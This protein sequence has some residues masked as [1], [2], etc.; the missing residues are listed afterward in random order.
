ML[1]LSIIKNKLNFIYKLNDLFD[2]REKIQ[3]FGVLAM[4]LAMAIFQAIGVAS[5]FPFINMIMD[6]GV[7]ITNQWLNYSYN[8]LGFNSNNS[9]LI[10]SG[11]IVLGLLII[12]NFIS[13]FAIWFRMRFVWKKSH[14]LSVTLLGK[15]LSMPYTYFLNQN[16]SD[17]GKNVLAEVQQLTANFFL[18]LL[19]IFTNVII[20]A[21]ILML[22]F[23]INFLMTFVA[24][25]ILIFLYFSIFYYYSFRLTKGGI[26]RVEENKERYKAASEALNG[27]KDIK[28]LRVE[29]FF[30]EKFSVSSKKYSQLQSWYQVVGQ[31]PRYFMEIV[32]FGGIV[33]FIIFLVAANKPLTEIIPLVSFFA[34]AGYRLLPSFQD[35]FNSL[36]VLKFNTAVLDKIH[37]DMIDGD[38]GK[39]NIQFD[40]EIIQPLPFNDRIELKNI[41]FSYPGNNKLALENIDL[42]INKGSFI[43]FIGK[44]GA[45]K[46][47][48]VDLLLGLLHPN[49]GL[50]TV[51]GVKITDKNIRD[52][53]ANLGYVPQQI[54]LADDSITRNIA[55]G[56][57][58]EKIDLEQVKNAAQMANLHDFII[59]ELPHGYSTMIGERGIRLSGGQRQRIGIARALY[60]NPQILIFDE[61]T[62]SLDNA[63]EKDVLNAIERVAKLKTMIVIAHRLTTVKNSDIVYLMKKGKIV[64]KGKYNEMVVN[65]LTSEN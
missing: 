39:D 59:K 5:I 27:V 31:M 49:K 28:V 26:R 18:P 23:Y 35:I 8:V 36:T 62:S 45:G 32:A 48:L 22:L 13:A 3:F 42:V 34:F 4:S 52:W 30:L 61:A 57:S 21:V 47:T 12:G 53:Q 20:V 56:L 38:L 24:S 14:D 33:G 41:C 11:F 25:V 65:N 43:A 64:N 40:R 44:T 15:Y 7:I 9:F 37:K 1:I 29:K 46:T 50:F 2:G 54:Y 58:D 55:F 60:Y 19:A 10:F 17:L 51:D 16:T 63:T 6:P